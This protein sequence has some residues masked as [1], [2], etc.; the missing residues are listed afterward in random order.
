MRKIN[1][2]W[3][4]CSKKLGVVFECESEDAAKRVVEYDNKKEV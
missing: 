2:K 3:Y 1:G 4:V